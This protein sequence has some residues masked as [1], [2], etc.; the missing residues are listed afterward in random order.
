M[1]SDITANDLV[2]IVDK[3]ELISKSHLPTRFPTEVWK[4]TFTFRGRSAVVRNIDVSQLL[5][6]HVRLPQ[7]AIKIMRQLMLP[8][9]ES[10]LVVNSLTSQFKYVFHNLSSVS[11]RKHD[12]FTRAN[13][14]TWSDSLELLTSS[15]G[16][17][18]CT[19][20]V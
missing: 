2:G 7:I 15:T 11:G 12:L 13:I 14:L 4:G 6:T 3:T 9:Y 18:V 17:E 10:L 19:H 1:A 5:V 20:P 16:S 8:D